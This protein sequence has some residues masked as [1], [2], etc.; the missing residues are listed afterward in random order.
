MKL[1]QI[2]LLAFITNSFSQ[3][4]GD[5]YILYNDENIK[6]RVVSTEH[7]ELF[8][9]TI[10]E[11]NPVRYVLGF[12][13]SGKIEVQTLVAGRTPPTFKFVYINE[14]GENPAKKVSGKEIDNILDFT[15]MSN[16]TDAENFYNTLQLFDNIYFIYAD[17]QSS[18]HLAKKVKFERV[19]GL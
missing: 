7:I 18:E 12:D 3:K 15:E 4:H 13:K 19:A 1:L 16:L 5:L 6:N 17:N 10:Q 2:L 11:S 8:Q 14:H 9:F